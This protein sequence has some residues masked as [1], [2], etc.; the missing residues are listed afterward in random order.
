MPGHNRYLICYAVYSYPDIYLNI[1][2]LVFVVDQVVV[3]TL[4]LLTNIRAR[5]CAVHVRCVLP[6]LLRCWS[7]NINPFHT[8]VM[9]QHSSHCK[10]DHKR[11]DKAVSAAEK[12]VGYPTSF[13]NLRFWLSDEM[14]NVAVNLRKL[15]GTSHPLMNTAKGLLFDSKENLQTRG[16]IVLLISKAAGLPEQRKQFPHHKLD[17]TYSPGLDSLNNPLSSGDNGILATQR[18]LAE[19]TEMIHTA[20]VL[21]KGVININLKDRKKPFDAE[22]EDLLYGNKMSL[23]SGDYLLAKASAGLAALGNTYV[24]EV[25]ASS[26]TD[27]MESAFF[28]D[29]LGTNCKLDVDMWEQ[30][31]YKNGASLYAKACQSAL[32]L[33]EHPDSTTDNAFNFGKYFG[34]LRQ[35]KVDMD[36][37]TKSRDTAVESLCHILSS[38]EIE[39]LKQE[40]ISGAMDSI[41]KFENE[42]ARRALINIIDALSV[43]IGSR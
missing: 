40:Y 28:L 36:G 41:Y 24:V 10:T 19:I 37:V 7:G 5:R 35:M 29:D 1:V 42:E 26:I 17:D 38:D 8:S 15:I 23:L 16:L 31:S 43:N 4:M 6:Q 34:L 3:T 21:H 12:V 33:T 25:M 2:F 18:S 11:W 27:L 9:L 20:F 13:M 22:T 39:N 32:M 30:Y 14:S